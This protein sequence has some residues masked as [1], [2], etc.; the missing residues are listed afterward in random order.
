MC[1]DE[2]DLIHDWNEAD[3][4]EL[5]PAR[6]SVHLNDETLR[7]GLQSPSAIAPSVDSKRQIVHLLAELGIDALDL[8]L[9]GAGPHVVADVTALAREI[10][11][12][13]LPIAANC[14]ART[15]A[16]DILPV[17]EIAQRTGL[18]IE[19]A[20]FLGSSPIRQYAE[21]WDMDRLLRLTHDAVSLA[22]KERLP[23]MYVTEDTTRAKPDDIRRLYTA[24]VEA[25]ARR[26][27]IADTVGHATPSGARAVTRFVRDVVDA[28]G[29]TVKI[30]WHGHRDRGLSV[31]NA[32]AAAAAGADRLHATVLGLGERVGNTPL[33]HLLVNFHLLGWR[34]GDLSRLPDLCRL[35]AE[36]TGVP[37]PD[38]WP[39]LGLDAFRT[40]TG[41]HAAAIIKARAKG[42]DWLADRIYSGVPASLVGR[43]QL[44][45]VGPMSG[46]SNVT[47]WLRDHGI[48]PVEGLEEAIFECAK[49]ADE[50]LGDDRILA[51]CADHGVRISPGVE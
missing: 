37:F 23:V 28:T 19:V 29:E 41:V 11:D 2:R 13:N 44:I 42:Q 20:C 43:R 18:E 10:V 40:G 7:D 17:V 48:E 5:E 35:V 21:G 9:P 39:I 33:D 34:Q 1:P 38:N 26:V 31:I 46:M 6:A 15:V 16:A 32:L 50:V 30:D 36:A 51:I 3:G 49:R 47:C 22:A 45:E 14:A 4:T 12:H 25:G 24:A 8:G 27:C